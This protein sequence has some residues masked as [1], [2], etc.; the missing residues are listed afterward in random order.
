MADLIITEKANITAIADKVRALDNSSALLNFEEM[1]DK[2]TFERQNVDGALA[3]LAEKGVEVPEGST[4]AALPELIGNIQIGSPVVEKKDV[5]FYDYDGTLLYS[6]TVEEANAL[7]ALPAGPTHEGLVFDGWNWSLEDVKSLTR[8]MDI[9]AMFATDDGT[10][11]IYIH[12]GE[13][14]NPRFSLCVNGT[15]TV[16]WGDGTAYDALTGTDLT[17]AQQTPVHH[18]AVPGDYVIRFSVNGEAQLNENFSGINSKWLRESTTKI[19]IGENITIGTSAFERYD[20]LLNIT[21]PS[22]ITSLGAYAFSR[23][24][25]LSSITIPSGVTRLED[26]VFDSCVSLSTVTVPKSIEYFG[27]NPFACCHSLQSITLPDSL[28]FIGSWG[29]YECSSLSNIIIPARANTIE[30]NAF[31]SCYLLSNVVVP[32]DLMYIREGAFKNCE[33]L[34]NITI[35]NNNHITD[36]GNNAFYYCTSLSSINIPKGATSIKENAFEFCEALLDITIPNGVKYINASAFNGCSSLST[37][38]FPNGLE[39][40]GNQAFFNCNEVICFDFTQLSS[41]PT[42][43]S[44]NAL[45]AV[46]TLLPDCE[47]RVPASLAEQWKAATNWTVYADHIVGV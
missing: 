4:A 37:V 36:I 22:R 7:T 15:V 14:T 3:A 16:D 29:F 33:S 38:T 18:Y 21:I 46:R 30:T 47:I 26:G 44:Q 28:T 8:P 35:P 11:R 31:E 25:S 17:V 5:S 13:R 39:S 40:I 27:E 42:L 12:L 10:T 43:S 2:L 23:C 20:S 19:E 32:E 6:Y 34:S 45:G 41:I 1:K 24:R 9:G